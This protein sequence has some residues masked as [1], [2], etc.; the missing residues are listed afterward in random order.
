MRLPPRAPW[1]AEL[2]LR[3]RELFWLKLLGTTL[4]TTVFFV[5]YFHLLRHPA[6]PVT[7]MPLTWLDALVPFQPAMLVPYLSLWLYI[8]VAPGLQ[9]GF[10]PLAVYGLWMTALL[11]TGLAIFYFWPTAVPPLAIDRSGH[12]GFALLEGVDASGN[13]CPSMHVA[14]SVFTAVRLHAVLREIGA[15][16]L[17]RL[18]NLVW[19]L[20]IAWSTMA[21]RQ[22]VALDVLGGVLLGLAFAWP[23]LRWRP[24]S[25]YHPRPPST[26]PP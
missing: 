22:H 12:P 21:V 23:S 2:A 17:W 20:L 16:A 19:V 9:R 14:A 26:T 24:A 1:R 13:A 4:W 8:G 6:H 18:A 10:W 3:A 7:V 15:P 11:L 5:G 25:G